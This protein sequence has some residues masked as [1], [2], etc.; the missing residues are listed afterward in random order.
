MTRSELIEYKTLY[1]KYPEGGSHAWRALALGIAIAALAE[2]EYQS[3]WRDLMRRV[4]NKQPL[5]LAAGSNRKRVSKA[6]PA[7]PSTRSIPIR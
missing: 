5:R 2:E 4:R 6:R 7:S 3:D 1:A